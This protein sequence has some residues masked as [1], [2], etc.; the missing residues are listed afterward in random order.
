MKYAG[1]ML[2]LLA[3]RGYCEEPK[4]YPT[5]F[6]DWGIY[7][8]SPTYGSG[9]YNWHYIY[10]DSEPIF[11]IVNQSPQTTD[12]CLQGISLITGDGN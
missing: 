6:T 11:T 1:L 4:V 12:S 5:N 9:A 10:R 3:L 2:F 8:I 7:D